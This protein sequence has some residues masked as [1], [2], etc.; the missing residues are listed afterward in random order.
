[1]RSTSKKFL[2]ALFACVVLLPAGARGQERIVLVET[3]S[4]MPEPLYKNWIEA[5]HKQ[6]TFTEIR[7][8]AVG[9]AESARNVL[10]GSGDFGGGDAPIPEAQL[11]AA[12]KPILELPSVLI[13]IVIIYELPDVRGELK[14]TGPLAANIFLGKIK[15]WN[16][17]AIAR[18]N[19]EMKLPDL[20]IQV[21]HRNEGKGSNYV[22]SDY[23]AKVSAEF[24]AAAGRSESPKWPIGQAFQRSQDLIAK[25]RSTPGAIGYTE[26]NLAVS[27][28]AR[29]ASIK[30]AAGE[31]VK[32]STR[33][34][35]AAASASGSKMS[36][37]FRLSLTNA[38]GKESYPISSFTWIYV[39]VVAKEPGRG[40]AVA[41]YLKW[42]Y[43][44]GQKIA[45]EQGYATLPDDVLE[46][47]I[48]KA[49]TVR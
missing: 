4:S 41:S 2:D 45:Q 27:S 33:S 48:A 13:G 21:L 34:I 43:T 10:A 32:P 29:I 47:V 15:A 37:D 40:A 19:P 1:V 38:P 3:G 6:Q 28:G 24:L 46:K 31:F 36:N 11:R 35:A 16:D 8:M 49:L 17:P 42:A 18:L 5:Y 23:L 9:T 30:N 25:L 26:L 12:Q 14:L 39:P 7:Y 22:L 44:S 20:P